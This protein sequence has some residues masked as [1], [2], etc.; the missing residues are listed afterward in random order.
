LAAAE[1]KGRRSLIGV[2]A[3]TNIYRRR[4]RAQIVSELLAGAG[5]AVAVA[6]VFA[7]LV[8]NTSIAGSA[9]ALLHEIVGP[10][11]LQL[12]ARGSEGFDERLLARV[13]HLPAVKQAAPVLEETARLHGPHGAQTTVLLVGADVSLATLDGLAQ[14]L[15]ISTLE[16]S[17]IALTREGAEHT[18]VAT[19]SKRAAGT[20]VSIDLRGGAVALKVGAVLG[21]E[22]IGA[23]SQ[24]LVAV[25]P[26]EE[27]QRIA[28]LRHRISRILVE[29]KP[30][31]ERLAESELQTVAAGRVT[32]ARVDQELQALRQVLKP[33]REA[34]A[35]FAVIATLLGF[36][37]AFNAIL[38][39]APAR[40]QAIADFRLGGARRSVIVEMVLF[41]ALCLGV[42]ASLVGGLLGYILLRTTFHPRPG[43]LAQAFTLS[44]NTV[45]GAGSLALALAGGVFATCLA[46]ALPLL[47][48]RR[49]RALD[50]V[51][52]EGGEPGNVLSDKLAQRLAL[53]AAS[54]VAAATALFVADPS[55]A[56]P[57]SALL[58]L[59]S[60]LVVPFVFA[61]VL[62]VAG[63]IAT[64]WERL[65]SLSVA[66][67][68]LRA[69]TLRSMA[70]V[71]TGAVALFGA[72]A[73]GGA[74]SDLL[75]GLQRG[76]LANVADGDIWVA[77][78]GFTPETTPFAVDQSALRI[79]RIPG[80]A[81]VL[82]FQSAFADLG[83]RRVLILARPPGSGQ[84]IL[85]TQILAGNA[86]A[87]IRELAEGGWI[88]ISQPLA[89]ELHARI[90]KTLTLPTPSGI[91][92]L[93]VAAT[94]TNLGWPG[95]ALFMNAHDYAR[96]WE[97]H[98]AT[99]LVVQL[100]PR[101]DPTATRQAIGS[102]LGPVNGLDVITAATWT[103]R[104]NAAVGEGLGQLG[105]I[106]TLLTLAAILALS[107]ALTSAIWQR[108]RSLSGLRLSGARPARLRRI[109]LAEVVLVLAA[110]CITGVLAGIYGQVILDGYLKHVTGFPASAL[111]VRWR[112]VEVL[113]VVVVVVLALAS[114]PGWSASRVSPALA[115]GEE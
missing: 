55:L 114:A 26:L 14:T 70:L 6:L 98:G 21:P 97:S 52:T 5:V 111:A 103:H 20:P 39:T 110:G 31:E 77:N 67:R 85:R 64:R 15:P 33:G 11:T 105:E 45:I 43:Y 19:S 3:L 56:L 65:T 27:L 59:A 48:L 78:P 50:A 107:A 108:R 63:A 18:D 10:A 54:L 29:A 79:A 37:L 12:R 35:L 66:I 88:A 83:P 104:F 96:L 80:V 36:L 84:Q 113:I 24:A 9:S 92:R 68:A 58:A 32:V 93:R 16:R 49:R 38:L 1:E 42:V 115:L 17:S 60:I 109:L 71:A 74:R 62:R 7:T 8:A 22:A 91:A 53:G 95:G 47:D 4:L 106:A 73:L 72:A 94:T 13:E 76:A 81:R 75:R 112:P 51:Y 82:P 86:T 87:A 100:S 69:T 99:A 44:G 46:S 23:I 57:A 89:S 30:G 2:R 61:L 102:A 40:R 101:A 34:T 28:N 90:G 41:Q 25:M